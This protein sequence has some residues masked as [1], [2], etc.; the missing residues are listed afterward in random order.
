MSQ[1]EKELEIERKQRI[2]EFEKNHI[3]I[4]N[5]GLYLIELPDKNIFKT[6]KQLVDA[7]E[8]L[9]GIK[10]LGPFGA[11]IEKPFITEWTEMN[12]T[13]RSYD[14]MEIFPPPLI[15]P[16]NVY[17]LWKPFEGEVLLE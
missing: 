3:K 8:H 13:I 10:C 15:C 11:I 17:N 2:E 4:I 9:E 7:Y 1:K 12:P 5:K 16:A 14:D 6:K